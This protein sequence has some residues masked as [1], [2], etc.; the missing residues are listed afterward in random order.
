LGDKTEGNDI[1]K[2][3]EHHKS[4]EN[5]ELEKKEEILRISFI[6]GAQPTKFQRNAEANEMM[7][8]TNH[9]PFF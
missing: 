2:L 9:H 7:V 8:A 1:G 6:P 3:F 5:K 4:H